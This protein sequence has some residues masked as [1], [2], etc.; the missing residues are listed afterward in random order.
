MNIHCYLKWGAQPPLKKVEGL[1]PPPPPAPPDSLP[2][3]SS[4]LFP[5]RE[6]PCGQAGNILFTYTEPLQFISVVQE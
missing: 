6:N 5:I 4:L 1:Q 3:I 2:L